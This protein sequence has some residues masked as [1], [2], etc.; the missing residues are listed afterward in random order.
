MY[1]AM[2]KAHLTQTQILA[3]IADSINN[4]YIK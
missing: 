2:D 1:A 3:I 4:S